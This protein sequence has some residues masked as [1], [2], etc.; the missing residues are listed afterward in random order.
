MVP[1]DAAFAL[2]LGANI[3]AA[4][5]PVIEGPAGDDPAAKRLPIGNLL[6]RILAA[7]WFWRRFIRLAAGW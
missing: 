1:P 6:T 7:A 3:G 2:V 4:I 5:N